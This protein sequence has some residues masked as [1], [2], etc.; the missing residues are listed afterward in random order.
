MDF[1]YILLYYIASSLFLREYLPELVAEEGTYV[2]FRKV[3]F[4]DRRLNKVLF[5]FLFN[6]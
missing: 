2:K 4:E 6:K 1:V 5:K 3:L